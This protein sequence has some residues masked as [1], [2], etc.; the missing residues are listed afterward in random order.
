MWIYCEECMREMLVLAYELFVHTST[1]ELRKCFPVFVFSFLSFTVFFLPICMHCFCQYQLI[2]QFGGCHA[3]CYC[4]CQLQRVCQLR[5]WQKD[6]PKNKETYDLMMEIWTGLRSKA[7]KDNDG[8]VSS[9]PSTRWVAKAM[10]LTTCQ[11]IRV[12]VRLHCQCQKCWNPWTALDAIVAA[13]DNCA[14]HPRNT[15]T[16]A[17][18][19]TH[20]DVGMSFAQTNAKNG[21]EIPF[22]NLPFYWCGMPRG[23]N[24]FPASGRKLNCEW[25]EQPNPNSSRELADLLPTL[26]SLPGRTFCLLD[27]VM[28]VS[29]F[30]TTMALP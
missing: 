19:H 4:F 12:F 10:Q 18:T 6:T 30:C 28:Q 8:Q 11:V 16:H 13:A 25:F 24:K 9:I 5:G 14:G 26:F 22:I 1:K 27:C 20:T 17:H 29:P 15:H 21:R 3:D 7:D 23:V 2:T